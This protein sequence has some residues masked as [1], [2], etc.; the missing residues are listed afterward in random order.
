MPFMTN[1]KRDYKKELAWEKKN[2]PK[3]VKQRASRNAARKIAG[4][5]TGDPR[6][7]DHKD[8]NPKNNKKSNLRI[9]SA[10]TNLKK[11]AKSKKRKSRK[12]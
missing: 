1:G 6:Q 8:S 11:E 2:K 4:L 9:V 3:R 12:T 10:K 7:V 5:K